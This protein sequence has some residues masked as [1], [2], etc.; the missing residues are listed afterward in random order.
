MNDYREPSTPRDGGETGRVTPLDRRY[1]SL[2]TPNETTTG[3][4]S[5]N[6]TFLKYQQV[7]AFHPRLPG[8]HNQVAIKLAGIAP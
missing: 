7:G 8:A 4:N 6:A 1:T 2:P 3:L 5:S